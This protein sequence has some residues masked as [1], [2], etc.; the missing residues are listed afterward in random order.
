MPFIQPYF[1]LYISHVQSRGRGVFSS[2]NI[3]AEDLIEVAPVIVLPAGD[4]EK[5]HQSALH[6]YYFIWGENDDQIG[7]V[8]GYGSMYNHSSDPNVEY[9]PDYET[10]TLHFYAL[11]NIPAHTE[12]FVNYN[13]T[14]SVQ[15][16]V[17]FDIK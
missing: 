16:P 3:N 12:L 14:P 7:I 17:W 11:K 8:M 15:D 9:R 6:D 2:V 1:P 5:I 4:K 10:Q 13:G